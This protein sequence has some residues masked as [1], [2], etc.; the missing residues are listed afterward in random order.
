METQQRP[1]PSSWRAYFMILGPGI[2]IAATGVGAGDMIAA[3]VS[4]ANNGFARVWAAAVGALLKFV[5]NE[6][7][8]RCDVHHVAR[9]RFL[10]I[11]SAYDPEEDRSPGF[12]SARQFEVYF[13]RHRWGGRNPDVARLWLLDART[14]L[15]RDSVD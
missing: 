7:L 12:Y 14:R 3:T 9:L 13:E 10:D 15:G 11:A 2:A 6:G 4:G 5:L 8:A 1:P